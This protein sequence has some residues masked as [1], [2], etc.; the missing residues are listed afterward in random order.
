MNDE[1]II[2]ELAET[3]SR[4]KSNTHRI[5]KIEK[6]HE[7]INKLATSVAVMAKEQ[8]GMRCDISDTAEAVKSVKAGIDEINGKAGKRWEAVVE[9]VILVIV[10]AVIAWVRARLGIG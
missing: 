8:E 4:S 10:G 9:K 7:A 6:D 1:Q 2:K 3:T 5:D